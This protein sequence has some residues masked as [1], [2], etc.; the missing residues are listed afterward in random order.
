MAQRTSYI[1]AL[2][3]VGHEKV[4]LEQLF[5]IILRKLGAHLLVIV[6]FAPKQA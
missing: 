6:A 1:L 3:W 4:S 5:T 2:L